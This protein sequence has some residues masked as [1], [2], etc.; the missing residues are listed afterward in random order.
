MKLKHPATWLE[1]R[2]ETV[3]LPDGRS[4]E[5]G[6]EFTVKG[7]P[8]SDGRYAFRYG[9]G[10]AAGEANS[11]TCYGPVGAKDKSVRSFRPDHITTIHRKK[12]E[13]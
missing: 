11:V 13:R 12:V 9:Y 7:T 5:V 8:Q 3:S 2:L 6:D 4:L 1:K 10:V